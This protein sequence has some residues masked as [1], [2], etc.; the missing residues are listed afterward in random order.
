MQIFEV[1][2][3][4]ATAST[5]K[6]SYFEFLRISSMSIGIYRLL[7]GS[8]DMQ[9]PHKQDEVYFVQKGRGNI[10]VDGITHPVSPGSIIYVPALA[11]H[12]FKE[13]AEDLELLVFFAPAEDG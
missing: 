10:E 1:N 3:V 2:T 8:Q 11:D 6:K 13:I 4:L 12:R 5:F 7:A 9:K